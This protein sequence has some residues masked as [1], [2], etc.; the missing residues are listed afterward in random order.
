VEEYGDD[1]LEMDGT[2]RNAQQERPSARLYARQGVISGICKGPWRQL[3]G[4][5]GSRHDDIFISSINRQVGCWEQFES[6][7]LRFL[8]AEEL[9]N[10]APQ[11]SDVDHLSS[12]ML[13]FR[14]S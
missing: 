7:K 1:N 13:H 12:L 4:R 5:T 10:A 14:R 2:F 8:V 6:S 11:T 9:K 3:E